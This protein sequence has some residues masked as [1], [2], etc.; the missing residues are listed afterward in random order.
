MNVLERKQV[1]SH[2]DVCTPLVPLSKSHLIFK[3]D[4]EEPTFLIN[5]KDILIG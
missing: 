5:Y 1:I 3:W 2:T 4:V